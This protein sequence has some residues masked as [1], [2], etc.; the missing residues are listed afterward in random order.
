VTTASNCPGVYSTPV[1]TMVSSPDDDLC[2]TAL[3][4]RTSTVR[5]VHTGCGLLR[6]SSAT[7]GASAPPSQRPIS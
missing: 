1:F 2:G 3:D 4:E 6:A 7:L 5:P